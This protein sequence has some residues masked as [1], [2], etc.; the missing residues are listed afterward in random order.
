MPDALVAAD[1]DLAPD[2]RL[3]LPAQVA[4]DPEVLL[5][6]LADLDQ[7]LVV[8]VLGAQVQVDPGLGEGLPGRVRPI[9]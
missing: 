8:Q 2:V 3:D 6:V 5:D 1:L 4:L 9:P 7:V